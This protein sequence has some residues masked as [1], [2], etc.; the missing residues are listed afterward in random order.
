MNNAEQSAGALQA[1]T[2]NYIWMPTVFPVII[3]ILILFYDLDGEKRNKI[4][5]E[6]RQRRQEKAAKKEAEAK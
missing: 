4:Q 6:L 1:I 2:A 3:V 5:E